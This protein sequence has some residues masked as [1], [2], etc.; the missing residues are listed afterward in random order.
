V[1]NDDKIDAGIEPDQARGGGMSP[2]GVHILLIG[3]DPSVREVLADIRDGSFIVECAPRLVDGLERLRGAGIAAVVLELSLPDSEG[4]ATFEQVWRA[5]PHVPILVI[6][7][8]DDEDVALQAVK[9]GA[10]D[11]LRR[12]RLDGQTLT[13]VLKRII[14]RKAADEALFLEQQRAAVTLNSIGDAVLSTDIRGTVTYLNPVAERMTGWPRQEALGRPLAEVFRIVDAATREPAR[15]PLDQAMQLERIVGLTPNCLLIRRDGRETAIEDSASPI[16]DRGG[17]VIGAVIVFKDV[18]EVRAMSLQAVYLAQHDFLTDLPNRM[19]L[20][21]RLTQAVSLARRRDLRLAVLF[22]DLDRFKHVNDSLGHV[23]GDTLLQS[24]ARR[25]VTCVRSSDTVSRQ[26]GDEFV[27]LLSEIKHPDDAAASAQKIIAALVAPHDVAHH[28]LHVTVTIG[29][30][31]FPDDGPDA[32]TLIKCADTAMYH[33]K[34]NG[35]NDY[36]FFEPEM[37]ARAVERQCIEAGLRRALARH[38]FVLH[39]QPK[40]AL[41]T[42]VVTGAEALIRW[43]HPERGLLLPKD[44]V[45][46]AEDCGLIVPIGRWVLREACRQAEAWIEEGRRPVAV[47][48]NISAVEFRDARFLENV[49]TVLNETRLEARYLELELT[50][51]SLIQHAESTTRVLQALKDMGVQVAV[52]D[53][54]T[55]YSSLSYLRRFPVNVLK[56]DQSFVHEISGDPVG[57]SI[58]SAVIS[59][60]KS[61][62]HRVIAEGVETGEQLAFLQ[63]QRCGEGQGYYFSRPLAAEQFIRLPDVN[64]PGLILQ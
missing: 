8:P 2:K 52:D 31:I 24:V 15:N 60:G 11:Y 17:Q 51:S 46:I 40:I 62:G 14:E 42:G 16:H 57:T 19:L 53:F 63:A 27:V 38:E 61:L 21:D 64:L 44:F 3:H 23:I 10:Q 9:R 41:D 48:V 47:A 55:G 35:R 7:S 6:A 32:E 43:A 12:D 49:R 56:I 20:N 29:I 39:Y 59:M 34:E 26:G 1:K 28:Q 4:I 36:Q 50:E 37:N 13:R 58:V 25:L 22:L 54:G 18:S 5:V 30:S 33:A 45:P